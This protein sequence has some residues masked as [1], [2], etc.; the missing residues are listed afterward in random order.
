MSRKVKLLLAIGLLLAL[1]GGVYLY[2]V[3]YFGTH[4]LPGSQVNGYNCSYMTI[5]EAEMLMN[6]EA[7]AFVLAVETLRGGR[8]AITADEV[9]LYY[10]SDG[11]ITE[12]VENQERYTWFLAFNHTHSYDLSRS[13]SYDR[14]KMREAVASLD[15]VAGED[16]EHPQNASV[17]R[18]A[19]GVFVI[20]PEVAGS[21]VDEKKTTEV[22]ARAMTSGQVTVNLEEEGCYVRPAITADDPLLLENCER[23]NQLCSVIITYDFGNSLQR[24]DGDSISTWFGTDEIG[25]VTLDHSLVRQYVQALADTYDTVGGLR[26]FTTFLG[27]KI[28]ISGGD[29]GWI[30]DVD[31]ETDALCECIE[32]GA[33]QVR[34]PIYSISGYTR[35]GDYDIGYTYVEVSTA[36]QRLIYYDYGRPLLEVECVTGPGTPIGVFRAGRKRS[37]WHLNQGFRAA[38]P[39]MEAFTADDTSVFADYSN[40]QMSDGILV[41]ADVNNWMPFGGVGISEGVARTSYGPSAYYEAPTTGNVEISPEAAAS[42]YGV[43]T[44]G[45]PVVVY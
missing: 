19:E 27:Q 10:S 7:Q 25:R 6:R 9:G 42:L 28:Q 41:G 5:D 36:N 30:I 11:S 29:F 32:T 3:R 37:P 17:Y 43:F 33:T 38:V 12:Q 8:E 24:V 1:T 2:G 13:L 15:C 40:V 4:Y 44:E 23:M 34:Q 21:L 18:N 39:L 14:E 35:S 16:V 26:N 31:K 22:I 20:R 45:M